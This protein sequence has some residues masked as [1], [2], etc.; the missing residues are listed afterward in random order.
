MPDDYLLPANICKLLPQIEGTESFE[1]IYREFGKVFKTSLPVHYQEHFSLKEEFGSRLLAV[2]SDAKEYY[3][4]SLWNDDRIKFIGRADY[5]Y[6]CP[7]WDW[8]I[9]PIFPR[10]KH[11]NR[12][13]SWIFTEA[14]DNSNLEDIVKKI[15]SES[16]NIQSID[17]IDH[18]LPEAKDEVKIFTDM[19]FD[20]FPMKIAAGVSRIRNFLMTEETCTKY[21]LRGGYLIAN[22]ILGRKSNPKDWLQYYNIYSN[23]IPCS[24]NEIYLVDDCIGSGSTVRK[25]RSQTRE[26]VSRFAAIDATLPMRIYKKEFQDIEFSLPSSA[27][28]IYGCRLFESVPELIGIDV[29]YREST[30]EFKEMDNIVRQKLMRRIKTFADST[31]KDISEQINSVIKW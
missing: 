7:L 4:G 1:V 20:I 8:W 17:C 27:L 11:K 26:Q 29:A 24:N 13:E 15:R 21:I 5:L 30:I 12:G 23:L 6:T 9:E 28:N 25:L 2:R 18:P 14:I 16:Y 10:K 19:I 3:Q 22:L 31:E